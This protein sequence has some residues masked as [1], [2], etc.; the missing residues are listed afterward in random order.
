MKLTKAVSL[1]SGALLRGQSMRSERLFFGTGAAFEREL[2]V[3]KHPLQLHSQGTPN[4]QKVTILLE[5]LLAAG[6][7]GAEYDASAEASVTSM[8]M[9]P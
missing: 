9:R 7:S 8:P 6:H 1:G 5:E 4:G 2:P 3:G